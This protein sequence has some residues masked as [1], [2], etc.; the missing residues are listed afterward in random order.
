MNTIM[1][2]AIENTPTPLWVECNLMKSLHLC[3]MFL[4]Q[5]VKSVYLPN[6]FIP[7]CNLFNKCE[8][9]DVERT[10]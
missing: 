5:S 8:Q 3:R 9:R 7:N 4:R 1:F 2:W 6:Y 10:Q